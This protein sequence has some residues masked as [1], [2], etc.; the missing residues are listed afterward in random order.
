MTADSAQPESSAKSKRI[1]SKDAAIPMEVVILTQ[2][3]EVQGVIHVS[4]NTREERRISDVLNDPER[5]FL[6]VT[7]AKLVNR[8][9]PSS[10]RI[11]SFMQL[12]IDNIIMIHPSAQSVLRNTEYSKD[13]ALRFDG[14]RSK[15]TRT[16][17]SAS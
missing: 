10:P 13:E 8:N 12:H 16:A 4:R 1:T 9:G 3:H 11:Y 5:R 6:A 17:G 7:D 15:F 2:D 14:L